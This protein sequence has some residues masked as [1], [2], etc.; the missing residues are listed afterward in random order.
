MAELSERV[1]KLLSGETPMPPVAR[2]IGFR[3]I[4]VEPAHATFE[5]DVDERHLN[6]MGT[7]HGGILCDVA[8]AAMKGDRAG[9]RTLVQQKADVNAPQVDGATALHWAVYRDDLE[10]ADLLIRSGA[11][12]NAVNREGVTPLGRVLKGHGNNWVDGVEGVRAGQG[13]RGGHGPAVAVHGEPYG[14]RLVLDVLMDCV[15]GETSKREPSAS[16]KNLDL[17]SRRE[18]RDAIEDVTGLVLG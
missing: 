16:E 9:L 11:G 15:V 12:V 18:S 10:M 4:A 13:R 2:L 5:I 7:L 6:P 8:D 3:L 14:G 17:V 1:K